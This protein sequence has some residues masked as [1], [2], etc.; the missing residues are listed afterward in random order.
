MGH[1]NNFNPKLPYN[2]LPLLP[3]ETHLFET[4]NILKQENK[5]R[6]AIAELKG[7]A[8]IIPNQS[9]LIN[10]IILQEAKD[11]SEIENIITT[12]DELYKAISGNQIKY[13]SATKEVIYYREA[14]SFGY[15]KI[16]ERNIL[17]VN[18]IISIQK[19][20]LKNDAGI[21]KTA[22]TS[23]V[24]DRTG[25]VI[26]TPPQDED[27]IN[28]LL[29]NLTSFLNDSDDSLS[30]MAILHYQLES[31]H[32]FYDGN[33]RTGRII[34]ILYLILK[35]YLEIPILYLSSYIIKNKSEYYRLLRDV[36]INE[37][38]EDWIIYI[39]KGIEIV[40]RNTINKIITIQ[41]LLENTISKVKGELPK[42]YSKELIEELF[43]H[44]YCKIEFLTNVLGVERKA[45]SR[46]LNQ[47]QEIGILKEYKIGREK[48]FLNIELLEILKDSI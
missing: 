16:T 24:N 14:L 48:I 17:T 42:I 44:P 46:Y 5:A 8:K 21:R 25:E 22:G 4:I 34:N 11:S 13:D 36:T 6:S 27:V 29:S 18:D 43:V 7:I 3:P 38:W 26:Y 30:K 39:L 20:L 33:G 12:Q 10:A 15:R 32:P 23:L 19:E 1:M 41:K 45:A 40:A 47:L 28:M 2:D 37:N 31:I 9:I 35:D